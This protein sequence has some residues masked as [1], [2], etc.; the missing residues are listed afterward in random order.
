MPR[1]LDI[2]WRR[3]QAR[4]LQGV[5]LTD[6]AKE[7]RVSYSTLHKRCTREHWLKPKD[8]E[9]DSNNLDELGRVWRQRSIK[10]CSAWLKELE[11]APVDRRRKVARADVQSIKDLV[12]TGMRAL[13]LDKET[14]STR[15]TIGLYAGASGA[16]VVPNGEPK[17]AQ[18][19][20]V[21]ASTIEPSSASQAQ[22]GVDT[23]L[24]GQ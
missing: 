11:G 22:S 2:D 5:A 12:E 8:V 1:A 10:V 20:D 13:G 23:V 18:V 4:V 17:Q 15:I 21:Q 9:W 7:M 6:V 14:A 19:I 16:S 3:A 24:D